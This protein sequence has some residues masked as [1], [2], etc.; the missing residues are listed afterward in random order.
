MFRDFDSWLTTQPDSGAIFH[1]YEKME[2]AAKKASYG[3]DD[4]TYSLAF[5]CFDELRC[6]LCNCPIG[7]LLHDDTVPPTCSVVEFW[8]IDEDG[9]NLMC[10]NCYEEVTKEIE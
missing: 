5:N 9:E 3:E 8:Q 1:S 7:Y 4:S 6:D 2:E 10:N